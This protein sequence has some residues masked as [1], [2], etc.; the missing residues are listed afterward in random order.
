MKKN[1]Y[2]ELNVQVLNGGKC[3]SQ[4]LQ[5]QTWN[6]MYAIILVFNI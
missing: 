6:Y 1:A 4:T 5:T 2:C 3:T